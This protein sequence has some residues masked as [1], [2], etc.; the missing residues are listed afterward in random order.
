M[1]YVIFDFNGTVIDDVDVGVECINELC[2][3]YLDR[4]PVFKEEYLHVFTFPV[5]DY[6]EK[7]GFDFDVQDWS[8]VAHRWVELYREKKEKINVYPG[9]KEILMKNRLS[10]NKNILLSASRQDILET[11]LEELG[12]RSLF[13]EVWG[14]SDIYASSKIPL[15]RKFIE[16]K[17]P[18]DCLF[19]GD[20]LHDLDVAKSA[21]VRCVLVANGH[22]AK[23]VLEVYC[24]DVV[25]DIREVKI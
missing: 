25:D 1:K 13:D 16:D 9:V 7:I 24:E 2:R 14:I 12:I 20:T 22:Q 5:K 3:E 10:G 18:E 4:G 17:D 21:G 11:Q 15:F 23:D 6:Y 19:I 8:E